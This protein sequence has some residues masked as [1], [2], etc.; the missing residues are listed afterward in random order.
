[1]TEKKRLDCSAP[2]GPQRAFNTRNVRPSSG[3]FL[4]LNVPEGASNVSCRLPRWVVHV[5]WRI[6]SCAGSSLRLA[7]NPRSRCPSCGEYRAPP[8]APSS[9]HTTLERTSPSC[10]A[11][12]GWTTMSSEGLP[13]VS[14]RGEVVLGGV[15]VD[16]D[17]TEVANDTFHPA[18]HAKR[19]LFLVPTEANGLREQYALVEVELKAE[20]GNKVCVGGCVK[21][22]KRANSRVM[23]EPH[24][25][26]Q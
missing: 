23:T 25:R 2:A 16:S 5:A 10:G 15:G 6:A 14:G 11:D 13:G 19:M 20:G 17:C 7:R 22:R 18:F 26:P 8:S 4:R 3:E 1:M 12:N 24:I 21:P 9:T